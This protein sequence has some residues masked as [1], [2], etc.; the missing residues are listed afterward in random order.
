MLK[1][2]CQKFEEQ[3]L[4]R[5]QRRVAAELNHI[6]QMRQQMER[7]ERRL[8]KLHAKLASDEVQLLVKSRRLVHDHLKSTW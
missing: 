7:Q 1:L 4:Y 3:R 8:L 5:Q 2:L 6:Y